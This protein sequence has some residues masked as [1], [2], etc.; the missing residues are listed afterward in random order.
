ML[1]VTFPGAFAEFPESDTTATDSGS[2]MLTAL[3]VGKAD[4]LLL[5]AEDVTYMIDTGRGSTWDRVSSALER[6]GISRLDGVIITHTDSDH[7]GGLKKLIKSGIS[8][9]HVYASSFYIDTGKAHPAEKALKKTSLETEYLSA[10][11]ELPFGDCSLTVLGPLKLNTEKDD[12][13]SLVLLASGA[14]GSMLLAGDMEFPEEYDLLN[15]NVLPHVNI[16]KV[17]NHGDDDAT[18][19]ALLGRLTPEYAVISTSTEEKADTPYPGVLKLLNDYNVAVYQTQHAETGV[20]FT[21]WNGK[22]TVETF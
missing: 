17:G 6:L 3:N 22:I 11:D 7:V 20:R 8:V 14:G 2:M 5:Q 19:A 1:S 15:A 13:N 10:G 18:S 4:C 16:L 21:V 12:N 9:G